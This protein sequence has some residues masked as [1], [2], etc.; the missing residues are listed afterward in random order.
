[1]KFFNGMTD[2]EDRLTLEDL[3]QMEK[4]GIDVKE[5]RKKLLKRQ[6]EKNVLLEKLG[7]TDLSRL[8]PYIQTPRDIN[9]EIFLDIV[10]EPFIF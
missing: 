4:Q 1:M 10:G 2:W 8:K 9:T 6:A 7:R 5:L 3:D